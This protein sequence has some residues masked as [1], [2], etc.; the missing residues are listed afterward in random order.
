M[1]KEQITIKQV[2]VLNGHINQDTAFLV[3]DYPYGRTLRCRR[4]TWI[5]TA[6]TGKRKGWQRFVSQTTNPKQAGEVWNKPH[7]SVYDPFIVMYL[8]EN[9]HVGYWNVGLG[10]TPHGNARMKLMG[11]LDQLTAEDRDR[12]DALQS[13]SKRYAAPWD[14]WDLKITALANYIGKTGTD[15]V[16]NGEYWE[17]PTKRYYLGHNFAAYVVT[18]RKLATG[19]LAEVHEID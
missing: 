12:Y 13:T 11:I 14:E 8:D 3:D 18:A 2:R 10:V 4:R 9:E 7:A 15:P 17:G 6:S 16:L 5:D 1:S 19:S